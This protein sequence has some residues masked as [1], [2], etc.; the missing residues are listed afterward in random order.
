MTVALVLYNTLTRR[1]DPFEPLEA[2]RV[3]MYN[4]GPTVYS[5]AHIGNFAT[6]L[7][8]DLLRRCLEYS[9]V[10]VRQIMNITDVG[11]LTDDSHADGRGESKIEKKA[12]EEKKDPWELARFYEDAFHRDRKALNLLDAERY[13]RATEHIPEMIALI[14]ELLEKGLAYEA[15]DQVYFEIAKFPQYGILSGNTIDEL[16]A[17]A[18]ERVEEDPHKRNPLDFT[19]WKKD[20]RHIMQWDSPWGRGFPGWHIEC[21]AMSRKYLGEVFDIHTGGEDNIFPH[22]ECEIAQSSGG[23]GRIFARYW[24]HRRHILVDGKKMAKREGNFYTIADLIGRGFTGPEIRYALMSANYRTQLNFSLDGLGAAR[25]ALR[26]M[27]NFI[28]DMRGR[29]EVAAPEDVRAIEDLAAAADRGFRAALDDDLNI[30]G[31]L[32]AVFDFIRDANKTARTRKGGEAGIRRLLEWDRV[33]GVLQPSQAEAG[34]AAGGA[35]QG[36]IDPK[37]VDRLLAER[38]A[39]RKGKDFRKADEIRKLLLEKGVTIKDTPQGTRWSFE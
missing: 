28:D 17:G 21:S 16:I 32:A 25:E 12:R 34:P 23:T 37:E 20:P 35:G 33:L 26:R 1:K 31:A 27:A 8:A 2:G 5:Y 30:S 36:R 24:L 15:G 4:C 38:E 7:L 3:R 11:H 10:E 39:A 22:H 9:G 6:F 13:P 19:L 14:E 29:P 18:G